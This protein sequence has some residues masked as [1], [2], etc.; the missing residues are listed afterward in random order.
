MRGK[1][2]IKEW[3]GVGTSVARVEV[4]Q[5]MRVGMK[6]ERVESTKVP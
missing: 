2:W 3:V 6:L 5:E 1:R 4:K